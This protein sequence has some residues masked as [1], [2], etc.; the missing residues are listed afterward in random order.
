[1]RDQ[2]LGKAP[3]DY[4]V[5][6]SA[7]PDQVRQ[8]FGTRRTIPVGMAFGV[9]TVIGNKSTGNVEVATFRS[10]GNYS[11]GRHPDQVTFS[12][13]EH[14]AQRRDFTINGLFYDPIRAEIH[15]YVGGQVDLRRRLVRAIR[16]PQQ[17]FAEDHLR[18][19][20][21]IRFATVLDFDLAAET[22]AA[23]QTLVNN[24]RTV[25]GER[26]AAEMRRLLESPHRGR[27]LELLRRSGLLDVLLPALPWPLESGDAISGNAQQMAGPS[28]NGTDDF[29]NVCQR[30]SQ[31][32]ARRDGLELSLSV[33]TLT[34]L[35]RHQVAANRWRPEA[36]WLSTPTS[37]AVMRNFATRM[38]QLVSDW[39]LSNESKTIFK[40]IQFGLP[41]LA[42]A[43]RLPWSQLQPTLLLPNV[44]VAVETVAVLSANGWIDAAAVVRCR[45]CLTWSAERL[46]PAPLL[47][48]DKLRQLGIGAGPQ[49]GRILSELRQRQLDGQ[50]WD[51]AAA[52]DWV[53]S[54]LR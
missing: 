49:M 1:V 41:V 52:R 26:I 36:G 43:D 32:P 33:L 54:H 27:G 9:I 38:K 37:Q 20:R 44:E 14:D 42:Q 34:E 50:L 48:G 11:D 45:D 10:D 22:L 18:M 17:R 53:R 12:D 5:A 21:A 46:N 29:H 4:D 8:I 16:D 15:D 28:S 2:L 51:S 31:W 30:L 13:P 19:L 6:T 40:T 3:K 7:T 35:L 24:I 47:T 25:S 39:R 23:I